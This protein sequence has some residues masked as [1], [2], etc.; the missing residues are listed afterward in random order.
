M[1][2]GPPGRAGGR[3]PRSLRSLR[4]GV[5]GPCAA[6]GPLAAC[7]ALRSVGQAA[8]SFPH[9]SGR[10]K[11]LRKSAPSRGGG[12]GPLPL[13][14]CHGGA[15]GRPSPL[16]AAFSSGGASRASSSLLSFCSRPALVLGGSPLLVCPSPRSRFV[17]SGVVAVRPVSWAGGGPRRGPAVLK[18]GVVM[19]GASWE[20]EAAV[21]A[22]FGPEAQIVKVYRAFEGDLRVI[23]WEPLE[24]RQVRCSVSLA[25]G[26]IRLREM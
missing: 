21:F 25:E 16:L 8:A 11:G 3:R 10:R 24:G 9:Y 15:P 23:V 4:A 19:L 20:L 5:R 22:M 2:A 1:G 17:P 7:G 18:G 26:K 6:P 14:R 12:R 13:A